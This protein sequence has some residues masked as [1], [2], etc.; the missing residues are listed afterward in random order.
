MFDQTFQ[1]APDELVHTEPHP[2]LTALQVAVHS[3]RS[4]SSLQRAQCI[5]LWSELGMHPDQIA[6]IIG[7]SPGSVRNFC[8]VFKKNG[9]SA[10]MPMEK[11]G[12]RHQYMTLEA[13]RSFL[14]LFIARAR[15]VGHL[16]VADLRQAYERT[17]GHSC[18]LSTI[19]RLVKRHG[20]SN[21]LP[22]AHKQQ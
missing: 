20:L 16:D 4:K 13:E 5:L 17:T 7:W 6:T 2:K 12:R 9:F 15:S 19:Y 22:S 11:G 10:L 1:H 3:A 14:R 18:S 8:T 21:R